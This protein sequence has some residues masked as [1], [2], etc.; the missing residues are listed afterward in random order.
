SDI[1]LSDL[2]YLTI[3]YYDFN[4]E[5]QVGE[6]IVNKAIEEDTIAVFAELFENEYEICS[7][8]LIDDLAPS[9]FYA[10]NKAYGNGYVPYFNND[11]G[12]ANT[13]SNSESGK[14]FDYGMYADNVLRVQVGAGGT[15][16]IG[17]K[18]PEGFRSNTWVSFDNFS[19]TYY[20]ELQV[21]TDEQKEA[22]LAA[23][24]QGAMNAEVQTALD[25]ALA[26]FTAH[27][28]V[29]TY[30]ALDAAIAAAKVS[31]KA[32]AS[33]QAALDEAAQTTLSD[34]ARA[35]FDEAVAA[36]R[37]SLADAT[38]S[39]DGLAEV[40]A[41]AAALD[42]ALKE[43][44]AHSDDKTGLIVNPQFNDGTAGWSGDFGTGALKATSVNPLITAY[45][46]TFD[47]YQD[48]TGLAPGTYKLK[49]QA[50][51]RPMDHN[52]VVTALAKGEPLNNETYL[53][54]ND[55]EVLV[56]LI[57]EDY[58]TTGSWGADMGGGRYIPNSSGDA[59]NAF[60]A[61][62]YDNELL[63]IV[64]DGTARIGIRQE[65]TS[66]VPYVGYDN[67]RLYYVSADMELPE[68]V[69]PLTKE[70][71]L[72]TLARYDEV[73]R[74][75]VSH[76]DFDGVYAAATVSL[77]DD[78]DYT[79]E[80]LTAVTA[81]VQHAFAT[82]LKNGETATGQFDLTPLIANADFAAKLDGWTT[83]KP[84]AWNSIGVAQFSSAKN[85]GTL[86][87][88]L[89]KMPAGK[90]TLKAQAFYRQ[91]GW[92]EGLYE[93]EHGNRH[94]PL[95]LFLNESSQPVKSLFEDARS[96]LA[97]DNVSRVEDVGATVDG[98]GFP[99]L[100][101]KVPTILGA[102]HYWNYL[103]VAVTEDGDLTFG[104]AF[105][106]TDKDD[107][108]AV[109]DNFRLY[110]GERKPVVL[111]RLKSEVREV[112]PAT[113]TIEKTF[114][115]NELTPF[116]APCDIPGSLFKAVY[117]IGALDASTRTMTLY[118]VEK[119]RAGIPCCVVAAQDLA[120]LEVGETVISAALPDTLQLAWDGGQI[121]GMNN[122]F[123]WRNIDPAGK[124]RTASQYVN[125]E[126]QDLQAMNFKANIMNCQV[127][128]FLT[129]T[130]L[131][132]SA[133]VV[134]NYNKPAPARRDLAHAVP[135][136]VPVGKAAGA[137]VRYSLNAD[138]SD[139]TVVP[140]LY[141][142]ALCHL[143]NLIPDNT[144][145]FEVQ[146][147]AEVL[148][149]GQFTTEGP[150]RQLYA[151]SI[152]NIRDFGGWT[153]QDGR[154]TRYGLIYRGGEVNGTHAPYQQDVETLKALG[155]GAEIDL[156]YHDAYDQDRET[157]HSGFGFTHGDTYYF[158]GAND[159][160]AANLSEA[161]TQARL[162][163][164][165]RF[166]LGH[167]REGRGV[168]FHCVFGADR[169][170]LFAV[171]LQGLLGFTLND[172]YHDYEITSFAAP[173]GNRDKGSIDERIAVI[174]A[175]EGK[176]LR[177]KYE[178]YWLNTVGITQEEVD[179]FRNLMLY[180]PTPV[181]INDH[182]PSAEQQGEQGIR[183]VYTIGGHK[184]LASQLHR[185]AG[186]YVIQYNDGTSCKVVI[187]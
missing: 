56:K 182:M 101:S 37:Q 81:T 58:N 107:N 79:E 127:R 17:V 143:P 25:L 46:G 34:E 65:A 29:E 142:A 104:A 158:A 7:M 14:A 19:L 88:V 72:A 90:Y 54:A 179:E 67:F 132:S 139:A 170:G 151:P 120:Q 9:G 22:I 140:V 41:I 131:Q 116:Y 8:R 11:S 178:N 2:R 137:E 42:A 6:L 26:N 98:R 68:V 75:A 168:Y 89:E 124:M 100:M 186:V 97:S 160:T 187:R 5:I 60:N 38:L 24:P 52:D 76:A 66:G 145:Y 23:V 40:T 95:R 141:G 133:S 103:E 177:D 164:E 102:G 3:S 84:F 159:Y 172:M 113:V 15:L 32:Y 152:Y 47:I 167:I 155:I 153:M 161:G 49:A 50:F 59:A 74:Q 157:N 85:Q 91:S 39:G 94:D 48:I 150:L 30:N 28:T 110:Y 122:Q 146:Q 118:P 99:H 173:A 181:G 144:Y 93:F 184:V 73:A 119:V 109:L 171:M 136:P 138:M 92:K 36:I 166:L 125:A 117:E 82:L 77:S 135:I 185:Q 147:G 69:I 4:H 44:I 12:K 57:T 62:L 70:R 45:D 115:A 121:Y 55:S 87:Q 86:S 33:V 114:T 18:L 149:K 176:T 180:D 129:E 43:D 183:A 16:R 123:S 1:A 126:I 156:R 154:K 78:R 106:A 63:F 163:E 27:A 21:I 134:S 10:N 130:Y 175:L 61:G 51:T 111:S 128:Q 83:A 105:D 162:K 13:T 96:A 108:W 53:Y 71:T 112:T 165:F 35:H 169:T 174:R 20:G 64:K 31:V 148:A 80:E